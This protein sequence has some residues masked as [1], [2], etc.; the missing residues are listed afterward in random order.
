MAQTY[1][2]K[3]RNSPDQKVLFTRK[4]VKTLYEQQI[5]IYKTI[6]KP[7]STYGIKPWP[8][9]STSNR[10]SRA[11]L[12]ESLAHEGRRTLVYAIYGYAKRSPNTNS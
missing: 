7:I 4:Q 12:I 10:N 5:F 9:A 2:R 6:L 3:T 1:F 11:F 8:T